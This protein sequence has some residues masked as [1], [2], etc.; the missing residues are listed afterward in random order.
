[1]VIMIVNQSLSY[2]A[3]SIFLM[4]DG[5]VCFKAKQDDLYD[6]EDLKKILDLMESVSH[7]KPF[8]L[9]MDVGG[10]DFLM[11]KEARSLFNTYEK[12][13]ELI[14]AE[15][16]VMNSTS[17]RILYNLLTKVNPPKF[18]FKAFKSTAKAKAWLLK[19]A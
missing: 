14:I 19:Q 7:G 1:M 6:V 18:P 17:M 13:L 9:L 15:A 8:L 2:K 10:F 3:N 11:T 12:A 4:E 5:I 16:V